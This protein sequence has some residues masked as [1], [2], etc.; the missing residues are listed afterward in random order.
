MNAQGIDREFVDLINQN[1]GIIHKICRIYSSGSD[2]REDLFQ[3]IVLQIWKSFPKFRGESKFSTWI[4]RIA[5]NTAI[6]LKKSPR[7]EVTVPDLPDIPYHEEKHVG[8]DP[9]TVLYHAIGQLLKVERA[10]IFLWLEEKSYEEIG[11]TIG[12]TAKNVSVKLVRIK[13][14]LSKIIGQTP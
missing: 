3:E 12:L 1:R 6:S 5:L 13:A 14:K 4:Y 10:L 2:E 8:D 9:V 11:K 7:I